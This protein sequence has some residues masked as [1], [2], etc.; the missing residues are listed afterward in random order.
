M[1][2][3]DSS[4][5][6]ILHKLRRPAP[7][8][9]AISYP[10]WLDG[11]HIAVSPASGPVSMIGII[12]AALCLLAAMATPLFGLASAY[13]MTRV[14]AAVANRVWAVGL[15]VSGLISVAIISGLCGERI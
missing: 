9:A 15:V 14:A 8:A 3:L 7:A 4:A 11:F 5:N 1:P 10:F 2:P 13:R 12:G 6:T